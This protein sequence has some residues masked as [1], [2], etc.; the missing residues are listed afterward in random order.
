MDDNTMDGDEVATVRSSTSIMPEGS[1]CP[2][3]EELVE[4]VLGD[5]EAKG[6]PTLIAHL[7]SCFD[8]RIEVRAIREAL[9]SVFRSNA[10]SNHPRERI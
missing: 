5:L 8:C 3:P 1:R 10:R 7:D 4:F 6:C 9:D 2:S